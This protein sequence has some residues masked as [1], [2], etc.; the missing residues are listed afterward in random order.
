VV[1]NPEKNV[2]SALANPAPKPIAIDAWPPQTSNSI[3]EN[4]I[5]TSS[6]DFM[7]RRLTLGRNC[8]DVSYVAQ[9]FNSAPVNIY[10]PECV[11]GATTASS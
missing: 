6:D 8:F 11:A 5:R 10:S 3:R 9:T 2:S 1:L 4:Q 7:S